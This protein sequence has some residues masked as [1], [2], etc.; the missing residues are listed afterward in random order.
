MSQTMPV[1]PAAFS[2]SSAAAA[3]IAEI[4]AQ[5]GAQQAAQ[6]GIALR[7]AVESGGCNGFQYSFRL[8]ARRAPDDVVIEAGDATVIV[9]PVSMDLLRGAELQFV[10][11]LMGAHFTVA[12]P[13]AATSCGCGTSFS[14]A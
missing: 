1:S 2:V 5:Q 10:D 12:N 9:D 11:K 14:L 3:R 6:E 8:D 13:N 4:V 7:V